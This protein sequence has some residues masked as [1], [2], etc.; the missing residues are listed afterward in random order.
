VKPVTVAD[1]LLPGSGLIVDGRLAWGAPLLAPAILLLSALL[2]SLTL[3]GA[4][5]AWTAPRA[6]PVYLLLSIGALVIRHRLAVRERVDPEQ[7]RQLARAAEQAWLRNEPDAADKARAVTR[8][9]P[10]LPQAWRLLALVA[11]DAKAARRADAI[12]RRSR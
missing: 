5:A 12:E 7:T 2:L 8:A 11:G 4:F 6:I 10:E 1:A 9:A 3:G